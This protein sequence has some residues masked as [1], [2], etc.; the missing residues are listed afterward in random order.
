MDEIKNWWP[1]QVDHWLA[2]NVPGWTN[3]NESMAAYQS[4]YLSNGGRLFFNSPDALV[5][6]VQEE[7]KAGK[8]SKEKVYEY[9][10]GGV[11]S[12]ERA[13]GCV[14]LI[15]ASDAEHES[16]F[17]DA[18]ANGDDVFFVSAERLA[19]QDVDHEYD[20]YDAHVCDAAAPCLS[21][22]ATG[23]PPCGSTEACRPGT[24]E[25]PSYEAAASPV[26]NTVSTSRHEVAGTKAGKPA[27]TASEKLA[28]A[29]KACRTSSRRSACEKHARAKYEPLI[30]AEHLAAA[31]KAC[32]K[33]K[34]KSR[35]LGCEKQARRR[36]AARKAS[37]KPGSR[38]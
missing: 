11:G 24:F 6:A 26:V 8:A 10:P 34:S 19:A 35:R 23:N 27:T 1:R 13:G 3:I 16:A 29:L 22:P 5:P 14:A 20:V 37:S 7:V 17:L 15:S 21:A 2:A 30:R 9:E 31:L 12:C 4:R 32:K 28:Q 33:Q 18:S 38:R 36:Y 25:T